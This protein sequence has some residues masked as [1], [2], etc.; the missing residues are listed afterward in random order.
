MKNLGW[1]LLFSVATVGCNG[2]DDPVQDTDLDTTPDECAVDADKDGSCADVDCDDNDPNAYP[3]AK[4]IPYNGKDED[5]DGEDIRDYDGDGFES[6]RPGIDGDDCNDANPDI[7]PGAPEECYGDL[8]MNCDG[9]IPVDDCDQDGFGRSSDCDDE[10]PDV[11]PEA[12]EIWYDGVDGDCQ[13]DSDFDRDGDKDE[14]LWDDAWPLDSWPD[15]IIVWNKDDPG[16]FKYIPKSEAKTYWTGLDCNDEDASVGGNLKEQ[17]DG[18]DRNCDDTID[19]LN[20]RDNYRSFLGNA[21]V[22]DAALGSAVA[23]LGDLDGS[24]TPEIAAADLY[25]NTNAGHA[26][27]IE[28]D[29]ASGKAFERS[30][31][32]VVD[33]VPAGAFTGWDIMS[34]GDVTEDG[35]TDVAIGSPFLDGTGAAVVFSGA[36]L[37]AGGS[38]GSG[39]QSITSG[40]TYLEPGDYA[41]A[42]IANL[43]D[44]DGDGLNDVATHAQWVPLVQDGASAFAMGIFSGSDV[45][46]GGTLGFAQSTTFISGSRD[47]GGVAGGLDIDADGV[48]DVVFSTFSLTRTDTGSP[49]CTI[50]SGGQT[51]ILSG[52]SDLGTT[53]SV[54]VLD[55]ADLDVMK[56]AACTGWT[57]GLLDDIT[58]DGYAELVLADPGSSNSFGDPSAGTIYLLDGDD[59]EADG[60]IDTLAYASISSEDSGANLRVEPRSG[61]HNGDGT[62]DLLVGAPGSL[63]PILAKLEWMPA[64]GEGSVYYFDGTTLAT[65][66]ALTTDDANGR[67][68]HRSAGT[69]FGAA[70]DVGDI[71]GDG[72]DDLVVGAPVEGVG[73]VYTYLT[74]LG[75]FGE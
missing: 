23:L 8:D 28:S 58:D 13:Y 11:N 74:R 53:D 73:T 38:S 35:V 71:D 72:G 24:G 4:E 9:Y 66:G 64:V 16:K 65:G 75:A 51:T 63:D 30:L 41:G 17:W 10:N 37:G 54:K 50:R 55:L 56:G 3:G 14:L 61:D 49:D 18:V 48:K 60:D 47:G 59:I 29:N 31:V 46:G 44:L 22:V 34:L 42:V 62:Q 43:G 20:E 69:M 7:Y 70:W 57:V 39:E 2:D 52:G 19:W 67:M 25:S 12:E 36:V 1:I 26:Y 21:G 33:A 27:I 15:N 68:F 5:C 6:N 32:K 45:A 40:L